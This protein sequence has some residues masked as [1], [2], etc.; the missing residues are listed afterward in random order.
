MRSRHTSRLFLLWVSLCILVVKL[1]QP[2]NW[3]RQGGPTCRCH[4]TGPIFTSI[5]RKREPYSPSP[6]IGRLSI[7]KSSPI[8][9][10]GGGLQANWT[11]NSASFTC[12][13]ARSLTGPWCKILKLWHRRNKQR[14]WRSTAWRSQAFWPPLACHF[15][16]LLTRHLACCFFGAYGGC[17]MEGREGCGRFS[18]WQ[19]FAF[20][21]QDV[22]AFGNF[23][24]A[25]QVGEGQVPPLCIARAIASGQDVLRQVIVP[26]AFCCHDSRARFLEPAEVRVW[27]PWC[28]TPRQPGR[29]EP[30]AEAPR[31]FAVQSGHA[32]TGRVR[33]GNVCV[34]SVFV[35]RT[36]LPH[37][38]CRCWHAP[39]P[40][41]WL[42]SSQRSARCLASR[43]KMLWRR[44]AP[45][46]SHGQRAAPVG[47][48]LKKSAPC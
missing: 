12:W 16:L 43:G 34:Q 31:T 30:C 22:S 44:R 45:F 36:S 25:V 6:T 38:G 20:L 27:R 5:A 17:K 29:L 33:H 24:G 11:M 47:A 2:R 13:R 4:G 28:R 48:S 41:L 42:A 40:F 35:G 10:S 23:L 3:T 8:G 9:S 26:E 46:H 39:L 15:A 37:L 14:A 1:S 21:R 32:R 19:L 7:M 18:R